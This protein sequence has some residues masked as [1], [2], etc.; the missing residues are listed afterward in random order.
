LNSRNIKGSEPLRISR[1][2]IKNSDKKGKWW[3]VGASWKGIVEED[4]SSMLPDHDISN[5]QHDVDTEHTDLLALARQYRM[6]TDV[7]RSIFVSIMSATDYQDA[8]LRLLKLRLKRTQEQ[9][10]PKVLLRCA[11]A[12]HPYNP[13][14]TLV[15]KKLCSEKRMMKAFQFSLWD[16]F[17][18]MGEKGDDGDSDDEDDEPNVELREI[19]SLAKMCAELIVDGALPIGILKVL[20]LALLKEQT[21]TFLEV[22]L[23]AILT[24]PAQQKPPSEKTLADVFSRAAE[25]PQLVKPLQYF[26]KREI[27]KSD[28]VGKQDREKLKRGCAIAVDA[29]STVSA[30]SLGP[31]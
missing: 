4:D 16:F 17:K 14:Y 31:T 8:H 9:E 1:R 19:V 18:K 22:M 6:N 7:R 24:G 11:G 15:A 5:A 13:Y 29:L 21:K 26:I 23:I 30:P 10:I 27:R 28:L 25:S 20:N 2:D 3:L 12:E